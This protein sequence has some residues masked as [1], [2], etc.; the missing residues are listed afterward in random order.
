MILAAA[1]LASHSPRTHIRKSQHLAILADLNRYMAKLCLVI[2][3]MDDAIKNTCVWP[4]AKAVQ[5]I[6][7]STTISHFFVLQSKERRKEE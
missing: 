4:L 3:L 7:T 2:I 6:D 1:V 5:F